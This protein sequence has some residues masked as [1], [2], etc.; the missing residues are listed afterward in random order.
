[1]AQK[2]KVP[3]KVRTAKAAGAKRK[4]RT[5]ASRHQ[6]QAKSAKKLARP[7]ASA[8]VVARPKARPAKAAAPS[9]A[10]V[11]AAKSHAAV[12]APAKAVAQG[13]PKPPAVSKPLSQDTR[14]AVQ[15][16]Q[17]KR[18]A[19]AAGTP[20]TPKDLAAKAAEAHRQ[21]AASKK[22]VNQRHGF[23]TNEYIVYPAHGVGRIVGIEEQ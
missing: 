14:A 9:P 13:V 3:A 11:A 18:A 2:K 22:P 15:A 17:A 6:T 10:K 12:R 4:S 16:I 1:M 21:L 7:K 8:P 20:V 23:K 5:V 19:P